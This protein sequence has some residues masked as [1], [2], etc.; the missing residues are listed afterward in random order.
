MEFSS[1]GHTLFI[2]MG[3]PLDFHFDQDIHD[4]IPSSLASHLRDKNAKIDAVLLSHAHLDRY[5]NAFRPRL[6]DF[7]E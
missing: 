1:E 6:K 7:R 4:Q 5:V 3:L 2:D